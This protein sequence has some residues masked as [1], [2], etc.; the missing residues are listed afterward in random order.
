MTPPDEIPQQGQEGASPDTTGTAAQQPK[1]RMRM[2][3]ARLFKD[4]GHVSSGDA[5]LKGK[6][7]AS[8]SEI[9]RIQRAGVRHAGRKVV[10][11]D[12]KILKSLT[13]DPR[14]PPGEYINFYQ[15]PVRIEYYIPRESRFV[16]ETRNLYIPLVDPVPR[17]NPDDAILRKHI[18]E[19]RFFDLLEVMN[20]Y[21]Q[22][23]TQILESYNVTMNLFESM[24]RAIR[25]AE[26][27]NVEGFRTAFYLVEVL[28][29]YEPTLAA[30]EFLGDFQAWN[31][32]W[33]VRAI[34]KAQMEFFASDR[35]V[36]YFI[37]MRNMY[38]Q[39][40]NLEY[41]ERFEILAALFYEQAYPH[42]GALPG[43]EDYYYDIFETKKRRF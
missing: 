38:W 35:T 43:S 2:R 25:E 14:L 3:G 7:I 34:N 29:E 42:R 30:L 15:E 5:A 33:L 23:I 19:D 18:E 36:S 24:S 10:T 4:L 37:K 12:V 8:R 27:G 40:H 28:V 39:E 31:L 9:K 32:N 20:E 1:S 21:P 6:D 41:D 11:T 16:T 13:I 22:H 17:D 26:T